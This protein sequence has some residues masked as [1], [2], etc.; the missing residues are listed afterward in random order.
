MRREMRAAVHELTV[1]AYGVPMYS[2]NFFSNSIVFFPIGQPAVPYAS[3]AA[4][5]SSSSCTGDGR[6]RSFRFPPGAFTGG[7]R[8]GGSFFVCVL[9]RSITPSA[10][11]SMMK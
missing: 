8:R 6:E 2:E 3:D 11:A 5:T 9:N 10:E 1:S 7:P 4:E